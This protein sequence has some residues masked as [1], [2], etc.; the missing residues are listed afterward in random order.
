M[1]QK[2]ND[3]HLLQADYHLRSKHCH[4]K[5]ETKGD[6]IDPSVWINRPEL[7]SEGKYECNRSNMIRSFHFVRSNL[8]INLKSLDQDLALFQFREGLWDQ[9]KILQ[10]F[11]C[12]EISGVFFKVAKLWCWSPAKLAFPWNDASWS[13]ASPPVSHNKV[14]SGCC[15]KSYGRQEISMHHFPFEVLG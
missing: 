12:T 1:N 11:V 10:G 14:S 3:R 4:R 9:V 7:R 2:N 8:E 13:T 6:R 15:S 5:L